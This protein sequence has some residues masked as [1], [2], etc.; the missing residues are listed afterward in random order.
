MKAAGKGVI[1]MKI[2]GA[3]QLVNKADECLGYVLNLDCVDAFTIGCETIDQRKDLVA[4]ISRM[5]RAAA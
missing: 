4:R 2:F 5:P 3:G 1:G